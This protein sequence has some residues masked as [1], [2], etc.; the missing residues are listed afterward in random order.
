[1]GSAAQ[2][3]R[4]VSAMPLDASLKFGTFDSQGTADTLLQVTVFWIAA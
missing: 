1:V 2:F 4:S 3:N